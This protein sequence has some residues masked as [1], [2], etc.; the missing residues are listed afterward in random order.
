[1][2]RINIFVIFL[3]ILVF[4]L[5]LKLNNCSCEGF[6]HNHKPGEVNSGG[7]KLED[8]DTLY[9]KCKARNVLKRQNPP[10]PPP[11]PPGGELEAQAARMFHHKAD[12]A[13]TG[14]PGTGG[15][16]AHHGVNHT[17]PTWNREKHR[18]C[19]RHHRHCHG[20]EPENNGH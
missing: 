15:G 10:S 7:A 6:D 13:D 1:M 2:K 5:M 20:P 19:R 17:H 12:H 11:P 18:R 8:C 4:I 9:K 14:T 3:L 16:P